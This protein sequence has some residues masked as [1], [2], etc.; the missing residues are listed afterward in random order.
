MFDL[1]LTL[2]R[3]E[4]KQNLIK[5]SIKALTNENTER[6]RLLLKKA[7]IEEIIKG[8]VVDDDFY[9][10]CLEETSNA[11]SLD[12]QADAGYPCTLVGCRFKGERHR[13]YL[14]H[15]KRD[16]PRLKN[17][18]CNFKKTCRRTFSTVDLLVL[19]V[20]ESHSVSNSENPV[21]LPPTAS[22]MMNI[23]CKC[24]RLTCGGVNFDSIQK[25]MTHWNTF[26][27]QEPRD[28]IFE[29]CP[30]TFSKA[31]MSR[32]HFLEK[33]KYTGNLALKE[34]HMTDSS[35]ALP[36]NAETPNVHVHNTDV[37]VESHDSREDEQYNDEDIMILENE[38]APLLNEDFYLHYYG[39]FL[40]RLAN[41]KYVP[42]S[43]VQEISEEYL[44]NSKKSNENRKRILRA[45]LTSMGLDKRNIENVINTAE[46]DPFLNAQCKLDSEYK[47]TKFIQT[48]MTYVAPKE[49]VL[50]KTEADLGRKKDII[51]YVPVTKSVQAVLEDPSFNKMMGQKKIR[52]CN[53]KKHL[54]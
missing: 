47:R 54:L 31:S 19:H 20:K 2:D 3:F 22:A 12:G 37:E 16:H 8:G 5:F 49:I 1:I 28:C 45:S 39:D 33:H 17:V 34:R 44:M 38:E 23:N 29:G 6:L 25:L 18:L 14:V 36:T 27:S 7:L 26:H 43:T 10:T 35:L 48:H 42:Q 46:D 51:H 40:N 21:V 15:L 13:Q 11:L 32:H 52:L 41:F 30:V 53:L 9:K 24:N 50:N 4:I